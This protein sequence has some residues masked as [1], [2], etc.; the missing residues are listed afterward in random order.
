MCRT[1]YIYSLQFTIIWWWNILD[2]HPFHFLLTQDAKNITDFLGTKKII[3]P[4]ARELDL[5]VQFRVKYW[6]CGWSL[7]KP[8]WDVIISFNM[9][10]RTFVSICVGYN[11][12]Q[13]N[14][15]WQKNRRETKAETCACE[16]TNSARTGNVQKTSSQLLSTISCNGRAIATS[17][18]FA[19]KI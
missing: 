15:N 9:D 14:Y 1:S 3:L 19:C 2:Q 16:E 18:S 17:V 12:Q 13:V 8:C 5:R 10:S 7:M 6:W 11:K 4:E